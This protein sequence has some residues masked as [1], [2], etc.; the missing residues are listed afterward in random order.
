MAGIKRSRAAHTGILTRSHD[1]LLSMPFDQPEEVQRIK[2][3]EVKTILK[4]LL[5]T[6]AGFTSSLDEAQDFMPTDEAAEAAFQEEEQE[7]AETFYQSLATTRTLGEQLLA[8]KQTLTG[9]ATFKNSWGALQES[10]DSEPDQDNSTSLSRLQ[11]LF[12]SLRE[13]WVEA[14]I[15]PEHP[16]QG[17][18]ES[19]ERKLTHMERDVS[20]AKT[21][22]LP[23]A[24]LPA[25]SSRSSSFTSAGAPSHHYIELPK[26][27]VPT[28]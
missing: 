7:M 23:A 20:A 18:L 9:L 5:K 1:R 24:S 26:I 28:S 16:L 17:E 6:E 4:T 2:L 14:D 10:L 25:T 8:C 15:P 22:S 19:C 3:T 11:T 21:R 13:Q 27:K 12:F